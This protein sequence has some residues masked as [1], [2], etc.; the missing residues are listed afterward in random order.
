[1]IRYV[2]KRDANIIDFLF[3][4]GICVNVVLQRRYAVS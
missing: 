4:N 3:I 2:Q 1:M